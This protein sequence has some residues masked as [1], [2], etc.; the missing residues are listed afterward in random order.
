[1]ATAGPQLPGNQT[2]PCTQTGSNWPRCAC[3]HPPPAAHKGLGVRCMHGRHHTSTT[4]I[5]KGVHASPQEQSMICEIN[6]SVRP[7]FTL[8]NPEEAYSLRL[9]SEGATSR[10]SRWSVLLPCNPQIK[11]NRWGSRAG[12]M[13]RGSV[14]CDILQSCKSYIMMQS[15]PNNSKLQSNGATFLHSPKF[16]TH[17]FNT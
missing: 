2:L 17:N 5:V 13:L 16:H 10:I 14:H 7:C 12:Q 9:C 8:K 1:M 3:P 4:H 6:Y 15:P 11:P